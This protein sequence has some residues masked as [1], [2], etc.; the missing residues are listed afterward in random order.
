MDSSNLEKGETYIGY[1]DRIS[2]SGNGIIEKANGHINIGQVDADLAETNILFKYHG[3]NRGKCLDRGNVSEKYDAEKLKKYEME[4][5]TRTG[6]SD[7][8]NL[9]KLLGGHL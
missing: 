8:K 5:E 7:P 1:V 4:N 3:G 9:N 2:G 6:P